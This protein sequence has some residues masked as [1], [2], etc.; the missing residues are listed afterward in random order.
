MISFGVIWQDQV[1]F[2][3]EINL[4]VGGRIIIPDVEVSATVTIY[5]YDDDRID[6]DFDDIQVASATYGQHGSA[7]E[8][9]SIDVTA[10]LGKELWTAAE[11]ALRRHTDDI[12]E[13]AA[14]APSAAWDRQQERAERFDMQRSEW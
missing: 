5:V 13:K 1:E 8:F 6:L 3:T 12:I 9:A 11:A 14:P 7:W 10:P 2:A 4:S